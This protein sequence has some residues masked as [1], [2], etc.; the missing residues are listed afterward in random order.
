[1]HGG[2]GGRKDVAVT[3][4]AV[5][6]MKGGAGK[7]ATAVNIAYLAAQSG[8]S[9]L[10]C[11]LDPQSSATY[12]FRVKPKLTCGTKK[13]IQGGKPIERNIKGTD[14][15]RLDLL[16][17]DLSHRHLAR[18]FEKTKQSKQRLRD[19]LAPL[20][21]E[22]VYIILDCPPTITLVAE[23]IFNAADYLL[24]PLIPSTLSMRAYQQFLAFYTKKGY[25]NHKVVAFFSMVEKSKKMHRD[26][27]NTVPKPGNGILHSMIP[28]LADI[29]K[30]G[31]DREPVLASRPR[32]PA[33]TAYQQLW[34]E[35]Q[36]RMQEE[37]TAPRRG[38]QQKGHCQLN[39]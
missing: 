24:V 6:H 8:A 19:M 12:Y 15:E 30:M 32:S 25:D 31:L 7:T 14:Y 11:D 26:I 27:V 35:M 28:Y 17:A 36:D 1:M 22:Y 2:R 33:T 37:R 5:Y 13:F 23:H 9:T 20:R 29:E 39:G 18:A 10:L 16:P 38:G 34:N 3:I 21:K 4:L